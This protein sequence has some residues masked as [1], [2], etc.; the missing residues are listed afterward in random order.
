MKPKNNIPKEII[1]RLVFH[2]GGD[3]VEYE[4]WIDTTTEIE[5]TIPIEIQRDWA[6]AWQG[7]D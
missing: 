6:N 5:Y 7:K 3:G 1:D 2:D 4:I